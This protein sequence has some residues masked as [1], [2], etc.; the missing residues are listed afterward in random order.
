MSVSSGYCRE[1]LTII[2]LV[3]TTRVQSLFIAL[4]LSVGE[5]EGTVLKTFVRS[6][7]LRR[8]LHQL[9]EGSL[10]NRFRRQVFDRFFSPK[11]DNYNHV[12]DIVGKS[13]P[14]PPP[15]DLA[16]LLNDRSHLI[17]RAHI[18]AHGVVYSRSSTHV[19]NSLIAFA[20]NGN[21]E[22]ND[23]NFASI[24]YIFCRQG[25]V[26][27]AVQRQIVAHTENNPFNRYPLF[28]A[29]VLSSKEHQSLEIVEVG[30]ILSHYARYKFCDNLAVAVV[31]SQVRGFT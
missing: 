6:S 27:L 23:L 20:P 12:E 10:V 29:H 1:Y 8:W 22:R 30:W 18:R 26:Q 13:K 21:V 9:G 14:V 5:L 25:K 19:G 4:T 2:N 24:K 17:L 7:N 16:M 11:C 3:S 15:E 28:P 31:L